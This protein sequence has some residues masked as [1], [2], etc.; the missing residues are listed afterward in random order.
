LVVEPKQVEYVIVTALTEELDAVLEV[1]GRDIFTEV[2]AGFYYAEIRSVADASLQRVV[3][4]SCLGYGPTQTASV[5]SSFLR[6]YLPLFILV[7]G[8]GGGLSP[9]ENIELGDVAISNHVIPYDLGKQLGARKHP[10][11]QTIQP[12]S[13]FLRMLCGSVRHS[14]WCEVITEKRPDGTKKDPKDVYGGFLSGSTIWSDYRS[15]EFQELIESNQKA[16]LVEMESAGV[17]ETLYVEQIPQR[18]EFLAVRGISDFP[19][20]PDA[21]HQRPIWSPY[22]RQAAAAFA[23]AIIKNS[24]RTRR[25][26]ILRPDESEGSVPNIFHWVDA[27]L[28][29]VSY[30][31]LPSP[32]DILTS[33]HALQ[34]EVR[35]DPIALGPPSKVE[36]D[37]LIDEVIELVYESVP[38]A[39]S[40]RLH[41]EYY[42][43]V[44][45]KNGLANYGAD[46][47]PNTAP[48][49]LQIFRA[50]QGTDALTNARK[51]AIRDL[52]LAN[53]ISPEAGNG[54]L[55]NGPLL[56][57][58]SI[59][60]G[61]DNDEQAVFRLLTQ[62]TNYYTYRV[63]AEC[64]EEILG[65]G[66]ERRLHRPS[67][68]SEY[69]GEAF[70]EFVH[71]GLGVAVVVHTLK[72]D[73]LIIRRR[74]L[75]TA[76]YEDGGKLVM[77]ANEGLKPTEDVDSTYPHR[78]RDFKFIVNRALEE[79]L[80]GPAPV[81]T[82]SANLVGTIRSYFLTGACVYTPN[83]CMV[84]CFL[85]NVDCT[86][87][88]AADAARY[89]KDG[90][91]EFQGASEFPEFSNLGIYNFIN[92]TIVTNSANDTWDE[93]SLVSVMLSTLAIR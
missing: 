47:L 36:V 41:R 3:A 77:S 40:S 8:T 1:F 84:L 80:F 55:S 14:N 53:S 17:G 76:N 20:T 60:I 82:G 64:S 49:R 28:S 39:P 90:S 2:S 59:K 25:V 70:Q 11:P 43:G 52:L 79:E 18:I 5:T 24:V 44:L 73:K 35:R 66:L 27:R 48:E 91:F 81:E 31:S 75:S 30:I 7:V 33:P 57:V 74:S 42:E 13:Y 93:G 45:A 86:S 69:L 46:V 54:F 72:D 51:K 88:Q 67:G 61:R 4:L 56:G 68:L 83:L 10:R 29:K 21:E 9:R 16:I 37:K 50:L 26:L 19:N 6:H 78:L 85:V 22:A 62:R 32:P 87:A 12:P 15:L 23:F 38:G 71:L 34:A 58:S 63:I 65:L 92:R 89:A